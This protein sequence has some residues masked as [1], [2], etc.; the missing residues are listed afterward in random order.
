MCPVGSSLSR[1]L[2]ARSPRAFRSEA[3]GSDPQHTRH[4]S[5]ARVEA[6][7]VP[8][9]GVT[10]RVELALRGW[11]LHTSDVWLSLRAI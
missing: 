7:F 9:R 5:S 4:E 3:S 8:L 6:R 10:A 1:P 11:D 2:I